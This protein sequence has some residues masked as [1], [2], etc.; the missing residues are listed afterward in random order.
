[1]PTEPLPGSAA[2]GGDIGTDLAELRAK[3]DTRAVAARMALDA[4]DSTRHDA[5]RSGVH[6]ARYFADRRSRSLLSVDAA[7]DFALAVKSALR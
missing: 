4:L 2:N 7:L 3:L 5:A 1:M 6:V